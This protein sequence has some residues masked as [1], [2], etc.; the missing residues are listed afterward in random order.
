M[1]TPS[2]PVEP[3]DVRLLQFVEKFALLLHESGMPR[4]S[5]RVF[6]YVLADDA[7]IYTAGELAAG[8]QVSPAAISMAVRHLVQIG[9]LARER[10]PGA[11]TD[12]YRVYDD[13]VWSA[14]TLQRVPLLKR[15]EDFLAE[16][17]ELLDPDRPGGR[18]IHET[19]E[20]YRFFRTEMPLLV[21]RWQNHR[22]RHRLGP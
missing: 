1:L 19:L 8:L 2:D 10:Q 14:I 5:A 18:R 7:E 20:F 22:Q 3:Y 15:S 17:L 4:M 9:L 21:E 12:H 11:R 16:G 6:A 13:D